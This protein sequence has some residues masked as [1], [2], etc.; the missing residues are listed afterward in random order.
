MTFERPHFFTGKLLTAEDLSAEQNYQIGKRRLHNR[1]LHGWGL[2]SGLEVITSNGG[3][4][5]I[6]AGVALDCLGNEI[7]V[8][9]PVVLEVPRNCDPQSSLFVAVAFE[10]RKTNSVVVSESGEIAWDRIVECFEASLGH[11]NSN[12]GHRH[13]G[14]RWISCGQPHPVTLARLRKLSSGWRID[15]R[16]HPPKIR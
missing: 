11:N 7:V 9:A 4:I 16:Y 14:G 5:R 3:E 13:S 1:L 6:S 12:A 15:R 2:V 8:A 10:E